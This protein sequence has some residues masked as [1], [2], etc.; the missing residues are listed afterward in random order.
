MDFQDLQDRMIMAALPHVVFD[1]WSPAALALAAEELGEDP[2]MAERAFLHGPAQAVAHFAA[3][4]D[5]LMLSDMAQ[6][7]LDSRKLPDRVFLAIQIRLSRWNDHRE[8]IRRGLA[9]LAMPGH[10]GLAAKVSHDTVHAI[11]RAA[12]DQSSDFSWYTK[13]LTLAAIYSATLLYW[14]DDDSEDCAATWAFLRRRLAD[15]GTITKARKNLA[16][17]MPKALSTLFAARG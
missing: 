2:S 3:L 12:G 4:A 1:G 6:Q 17:R 11:W 14:L 7:D 9:V 15:V 5:R 8:A 13:R 10:L 16:A